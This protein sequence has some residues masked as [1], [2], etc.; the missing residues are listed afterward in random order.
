M[1]LRFIFLVG[2][3]LLSA[4]F[5]VGLILAFCKADYFHIKTNRDTRLHD[6]YF[7]P[8][9]RKIPRSL[10]T[11]QLVEPPIMVFG[12]QSEVHFYPAKGYNY[13]VPKYALGPKPVPR[14]GEYHFALVQ[15][16]RRLPFLLWTFSLVTPDGQLVSV[17]QCRWNDNAHNYTLIRLAWQSFY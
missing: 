8:I 1:R 9:L 10:T 5:D 4:Y 13:P 15:V 6:D 11:A 3:V 17:G 12:N 2:C 14:A 16:H 7:I